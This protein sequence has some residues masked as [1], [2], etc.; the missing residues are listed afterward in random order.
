MVETD[1]WAKEGPRV[2][3]KLRNPDTDALFDAILA[4][5]N[6]DECYAFFEDVLT[7]SELQAIVQ[8]WAVARSLD[9]GQTYEDIARATGASSAT[10]SRVKRALMFGADG[11]RMVLDR[12]RN[13]SREA[14]GTPTAAAPPE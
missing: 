3:P 8:R 9:Q 11:Y 10:I 14:E 2:N 4:L 13:S 1:D 6:R 7:V 5:R 12:L